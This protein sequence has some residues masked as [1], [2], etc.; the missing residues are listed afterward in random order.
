MSYRK[1][2]YSALVALLW[3]NIAGAFELTNAKTSAAWA[4]PPEPIKPYIDLT[5]SAELVRLS[6]A[7]GDLVVTWEDAGGVEPQPFKIVIPAECFVREA[8]SLQVRNF[9]ACG[10]EALLTS[11]RGDI[12]S[13]PVYAFSTVM[14]QRRD[15]GRL[16]MSAAIGVDDRTG[17]L[18]SVILAVIGGAEQEVAI[19]SESASLLPND[20][21][22]LG[23][24]PQP[25]PPP[26]EF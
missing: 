6:S 14:T 22:V 2:I 18:T 15:Y 9:R 8:G 23:F 11:V 26:L 3:N 19:G 20:I 7:D 17:D 25:E 1:I 24:N 13:L 10:V 12:I 4:V 21:S 5:F 16:S